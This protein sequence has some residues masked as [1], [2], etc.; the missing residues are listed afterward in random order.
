MNNGIRPLRLVCLA[1][2]MGSGKSTAG[3]LLARQVGWPHVDLDKRITAATSLAISDIFSRMGEPEFR[4]IE[5]EQLNRIVGETLEG[6]KP[7]IVSLGGGTISQPQ[8]LDL[9]RESRAVLI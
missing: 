8:N 3:S 4:K 2:F 6:Q 5:H 7:R 1:G 9:L